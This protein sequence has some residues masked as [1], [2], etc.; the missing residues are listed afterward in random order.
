MRLKFFEIM[1]LQ[2]CEGIFYG[3]NVAE[4]ASFKG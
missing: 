2:K 1:P 4:M 3:N